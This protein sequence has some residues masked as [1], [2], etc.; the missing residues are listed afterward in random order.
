MTVRGD[1][2]NDQ[3]EQ[4]SI[5]VPGLVH[6]V[7]PS[8]HIVLCLAAIS[9]GAAYLVGNFVAWFANSF[10][11][12]LGFQLPSLLIGWP[13][14]ALLLVVIGYMNLKSGRAISRGDAWAYSSSLYMNAVTGVILLTIGPLGLLPAVGVFA[15]VLALFAPS[16][17]SYWYREFR[18]DMGPRGKELRFSFHLLR[19]SPLVIVGI[20]IVAGYIS[21]A[22]L[23]PWITPYGPEERIWN[24][25]NLAPGTPAGEAKAN[26]LIL[27]SNYSADIS[28]YPE[29]TRGEVQVGPEEVTTSLPPIIAFS[30]Y[31][32][33][34]GNDNLTNVLVHTAVYKLNLTTF[35]SLSPSLR[36]LYLVKSVEKAMLS[37]PNI[38]VNNSPST[39]VWV[40]WFVASNKT[41]P[42]I[43]DTVVTLDYNRYYPIHYW[44]TDNSGGDIYSRIIW[45]AQ[46]DLRVSLS[47]VL[48]A[49]ASGALIG[50][51][52]GYFG[53]KLD[54][55]VMR[56]TD[57][58]FAFPG[59]ILAMA[60][61]MALGTR[62][63]EN[64]SY[65]LMITWWPVYARVVRGQ[66]LSEREK[67]Y[68]EAARSIGASDSRILLSHI[69]PNTIQPL[70]VQATMDT[71]GVLLTAAGLS[72][73]G[74]GS[75]AGTAEWG[76]MISQGQ[77]YLLNYP[78]ECMFP[79]V[80]I[81]MIALALNL[82]GDGIRDILDPKL[83]RRG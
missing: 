34:T 38:E 68:V 82:V 26:S 48:V 70:I 57:I 50:A 76:L 25:A 21:V 23:A 7:F 67:L 61:V 73:I 72:F 33:D 74:F 8:L 10:M 60:I 77:Y 63:L 53:G 22:F 43:V 81:L 11:H 46:V 52:S 19:R 58:F 75:A 12:E 14:Q 40:V 71:G 4:E 13:L 45:A 51:A 78:W 20:L 5:V 6:R 44:G 27:F 37:R 41:V 17:K 9:L 65:A 64:I 80:A 16:V 49:L 69:I 32:R 30:G 56:I 83:R 42:W 1:N 36:E 2:G 28:I 35:D 24:D 15:L 62:N 47:V 18:E 3:G 29:Y 39:Y 59:L 55:M 54:E 31:V 66:V 79:G